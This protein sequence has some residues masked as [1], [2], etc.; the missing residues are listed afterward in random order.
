MEAEAFRIAVLERGYSVAVQEIA[1]AAPDGGVREG[2][3]VRE[4]AALWL[5]HNEALRSVTRSQLNQVTSRLCERFGKRPMNSITHRDLQDHMRSLSKFAYETQR[6]HYRVL[7]RFF[8]WACDWLEAI[9]RNPMKRVSPP[10]RTGPPPEITILQ[11]AEMDRCRRYAAGLKDDVESCRLTA[12]L[13]LGG[14]AGLRT[15]EILALH[16]K[17][18]DLEHG[19]I[20]VRQPKRVRGWRPRYV[21]I[22]PRLRA[23]IAPLIPEKSV[24][25]GRSEAGTF[26]RSSEK[27]IPGGQ[28]TLYLLRHELVLHMG[29]KEWPD[30]CL[31]HSFCTYRLADTKNAAL[32]AEEAGHSVDVMKSR[33]A[34]P[35]KR[36]TAA[37]WWGND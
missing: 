14:F 10:R 16:W 22:Q 31:R 28:R 36:V 11:P 18:I 6:N 7:R 25:R 3:R 29:W 23:I 9:P 19:E 15:E 1:R 35:A 21:P 17:D 30:N 12:Y 32:V 34:A 4:V 5:K 13:A 26:T 24:Q 2:V 20:Y 27:V 37:Q 33:Y 8:A